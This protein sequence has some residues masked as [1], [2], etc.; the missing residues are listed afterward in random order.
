MNRPIRVTHLLEAT[1]GGTARHLVE[2]GCGLASLGFSVEAVVSLRRAAECAEDF[3][4]KAKRLMEAGVTLHEIPMTRGIA[5]CA[6]ALSLWKLYRHLRH[7]QP[8]LVHTHSSKAGF[9]GR[10][11]ARWARVPV[12]LYSPHAFAFQMRSAHARRALYRHLE[13]LAG[14][15]TDCLV[16]VS[17]AEADLAATARILPRE[18]IVVIENGV[19]LKEIPSPEEGVALRQELGIARDAPVILF[20]GRL[21]EQK[22]PEV[23]VRAALRLLERFPGA[24]FLLAG[25]GPLQPMLHQMIDR[26]GKARS[27]R[28]LGYR[29]DTP[30][31]YAAAHLFVLPSRWEGL[32]YALLEAMAAGLPVVASEIPCLAE[33][34][35]P[36]E[37][38]LLVPPDNPD[39]L[40]E[41]MASLL[42]EPEKARAL[43]A[44]A[45]ERV[46][47]HYTLERQINQL[48][49]LYRELVNTRTHEP[50]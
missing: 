34:V 40:A 1:V 46:C 6:D 5:P 13:R 38:G 12:V 39:A 11:A 28:L 41:A 32:P 15:W 19:D 26:A 17:Q 31:L 21:V 7:T 30:R 49:A 36:G 29:A 22:A 20:V 24:V 3:A 14:R 8:D 23:F 47:R 25:E 48:A 45:R 27:V 18:R 9:L 4:P 44:S 35:R 33:V 43:G 2:I 10:L 50:D 37:D 42:Q 16:A